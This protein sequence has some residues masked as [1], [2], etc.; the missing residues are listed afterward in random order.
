MAEPLLPKSRM[1]EWEFSFSRGFAHFL[2]FVLL[3]FFLMS[4]IDVTAAI[5]VFQNNETAA[6][7]IYQTVVRLFL[8]PIKFEVPFKRVIKSL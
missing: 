6:I 8:L 5:F 7:F 4:E 3:F 2:F 1:A